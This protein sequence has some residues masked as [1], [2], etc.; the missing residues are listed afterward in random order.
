MT[1]CH[2]H[3]DT[4]RNCQSQLVGLQTDCSPVQS[5]SQSEGKVSSQQLMVTCMQP[6]CF[7]TW[8]GQMNE[9]LIYRLC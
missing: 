9:I 1:S 8:T 2:M 6:C 3:P 5:R 7:L 4:A